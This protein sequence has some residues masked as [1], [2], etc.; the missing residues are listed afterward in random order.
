VAGLDMQ[1]VANGTIKVPTNVLINIARRV[2]AYQTNLDMQTNGARAFSQKFGDNNM[3]AFQQAWNANS[4][5]TRI[6]EAMN[7]LENESN[8]DKLKKEFEKLFPSEQKRK[9][10][11]KQYKNLKS[12][13]AT[14]VVADKLED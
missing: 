4:K 1:A 8:P 6:F 5:D 11:L 13:A 2:Q 12:L 9:T 3:G 10:I 14:G 7:L